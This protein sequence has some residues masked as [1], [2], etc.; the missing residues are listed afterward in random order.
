[1]TLLSWAVVPP[2]IRFLSS[3]DDEIE[4]RRCGG[5]DRGVIED[6]DTPDAYVRVSAARR[7]D[8]AAVRCR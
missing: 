3:S 8:A 2:N 4:D 7:S 1:V 5:D 6:V